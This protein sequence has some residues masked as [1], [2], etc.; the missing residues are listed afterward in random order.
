MEWFVAAFISAV[1]FVAAAVISKTIMRNTSPVFFTA[2]TMLLSA[3]FYFPVFLYHSLNYQFAGVQSLIPL[4]TFSLFANLIGWFSYNYAIKND[5]VSVVMP[6]NRLQPVFVVVFSI[7]FL[8]E[9]FNFQVGLGAVMASLGGYIVLVKDSR[10]LM[11]PFENILAD[12]GEQLA[13]LS[14][15]AFA[16]AAIVDRTITTTLKPEIHTFLIIAGLAVIFNTY[17][18]SKNGENHIHNLF[19]QIKTNKKAYLSVGFIQAFAMLAVMVALSLQDAS[20]VVPVL[21]LQVPLTVIAGGMMF[22]EN[23]III[24]LLGSA[25]LLIGVILVSI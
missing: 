8:Q 1:L 22:K 19:N 5:P 9:A 14:A 11:S 20:K 15:A 13:I 4:I 7:L 2:A 3:L 10:H 17:L 25:I 12:R 23:N 24:K 16:T 6:L 21:Q 18:Y